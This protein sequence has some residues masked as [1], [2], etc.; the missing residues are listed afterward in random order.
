MG[1]KM[2][3][4]RSDQIKIGI[5]LLKFAR[6]MDRLCRYLRMTNQLYFLLNS[7]IKTYIHDQ[8]YQK[9]KNPRDKVKY[10]FK[11][12]ENFA[13]DLGQRNEKQV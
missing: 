9:I 5:D 6:A 1:K 4:F 13:Y 3:E 7:D 8:G 2:V 11:N 10:S 12:R